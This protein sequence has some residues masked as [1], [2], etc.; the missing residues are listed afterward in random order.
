[1]HAA[2]NGV[3]VKRVAGGDGSKQMEW[4]AARVACKP[5][6][7]KCQGGSAVCGGA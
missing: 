1:V 5:V 7:P 6:E 3:V 4:A 2:V